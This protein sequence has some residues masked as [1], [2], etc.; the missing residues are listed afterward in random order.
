MLAQ[1]LRHRVRIEQFADAQDPVTGEP[2]RTWSTFA[3]DVA[4]ELVP[5]SGREFVSG[6]GVQAGIDTRAT[7]RA[8]PG[9][10]SAMRLV[11]AGRIYEIK[12]VLPNPTFARHLTLMLSSG[13]SNG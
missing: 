13:V 11:A 2:V 10:V 1:R 7:V 6:G 12:A 4:A 8:L 3:D 9:L 5:L